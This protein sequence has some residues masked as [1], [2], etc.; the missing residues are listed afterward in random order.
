MKLSKKSI[1]YRILDKFGKNIIFLL[2]PLILFSSSRACSIYLYLA[3]FSLIFIGSGIWQY[4]IWKNYD[5]SIDEDSVNIDH[6]VLKKDH[7]SI[8][9]QRVQNVDITRNVLQRYLDIA[10]VNFET[11]GGSE[12]EVKLKYVEFDRAKE[13]QESIRRFKSAEAER[14][15]EGESQATTKSSMTEGPPSFQLSSRSLALLSLF[16][17]DKR[18]FSLIITVLTVVGSRTLVLWM[19]DLTLAFIALFGLVV[20]VM[21]WSIGV[22]YT[23]VK[24]YDFK[25][26]K[27]EDVLEYERGLLNRSSGSIPKGKIQCLVIEENPLKR[28][29]GYASLKIETA[30]Y[31]QQTSSKKGSEMAI[32]LSTR[33]TLLRFGNGL[34]HFSVPR[35]HRIPKRARTRYA[36]RY[37]I[38]FALLLSPSLLIDQILFNI[39]YLWIAL[40]LL[41]LIPT[42]AHYKWKNRG[43]GAGKQH[44][45]TVNGYWNRRTA[46]VPYYRIQNLIE[47]RTI[48]QENWNLSS[49][50]L[51]TAST[52]LRNETIAMDMDLRRT[53]E[54]R[55]QV[56]VRFRNSLDHAVRP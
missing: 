56:F 8:P 28:L 2:L 30:G 5:Y 24:F 23:F 47:S 51:D 1:G 55:R 52:S 6:G 48:L 44:F 9:L 39:P 42:A 45:F 19:D 18:I 29:A 16:S 20:L 27:R 10:Q 4:L 43:W 46:I 35:V 12:T 17:I 40:L 50:T 11:A 25:I 3:F 41:P 53:K 31:A 36:V 34:E 21:A 22:I 33:S 38:V 49:L 7:R 37:L 26:W 15:K 54:L 32:P 14:P 13:I